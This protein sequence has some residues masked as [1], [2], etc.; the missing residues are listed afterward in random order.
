MARD[1]ALRWSTFADMAAPTSDTDVDVK[2]PAALATRP[3]NYARTPVLT[4]G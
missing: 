3:W 4:P 2:L 1:S